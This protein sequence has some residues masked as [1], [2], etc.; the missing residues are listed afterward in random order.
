MRIVRYE[1]EIVDYQQVQPLWPG[2]I[3]AVKPGRLGDTTRF[4]S[5]EL[6]AFAQKIDMWCI[7]DSGNAPRR[8]P[9]LGVWIVGTGHPMPE[10]IVNSDHGST[11]PHVFDGGALAAGVL[12]IATCVMANDLVWHVFSKIVGYA[13]KIDAGLGEVSSV[14]DIANKVADRR[15]SELQR[16]ADMERENDA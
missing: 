13:E 8:P 1:L 7:D 3:V 4:A 2:S 5:F 15:R 10:V 6:A 14:G 9:I 16:V 12:H 11:P